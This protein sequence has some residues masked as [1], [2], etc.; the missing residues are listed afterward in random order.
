M[1]NVTITSEDTV[2]HVSVRTLADVMR[3]IRDFEDFSSFY[4]SRSE[5]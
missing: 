1:Y 4:I 3:L 5:L 2:V